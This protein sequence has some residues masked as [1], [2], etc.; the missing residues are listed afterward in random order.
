[1]SLHV[2]V[3]PEIV[4]RLLIP[5]YELNPKLLIGHLPEVTALYLQ[6]SY[7][8]SVVLINSPD[9]FIFYP[10]VVCRRGFEFFGVLGLSH[11]VIN[12]T[13]FSNPIT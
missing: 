8:E 4:F 11:P 10:S 7:G 6:L 3:L 1:M 9:D 5:G 12:E 13:A 2:T